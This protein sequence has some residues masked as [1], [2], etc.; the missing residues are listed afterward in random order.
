MT[1]AIGAVDKTITSPFLLRVGGLPTDTVDV[2]QFR[3]TTAWIETV[4]ALEEK[5]ISCRDSLV[6][7]L[8]D[9]IGACAQERVLRSRLLQVKRDVFNMR[10]FAASE[11]VSR[12][13]SVLPAGTYVLLAE[14]VQMWEQWRFLLASG[15]EILSQ[16]MDQKRVLLKKVI[17]IE[18]FR[19]GIAL[20]SPALDSVTDAYLASDHRQLNRSLRTVERSLFEYLLRSAYKTSPFSTFTAV[21]AG[22]FAPLPGDKDIIYQADDVQKKSFT[23]LNMAILTK[24][25]ALIVAHPQTRAELPLSLTPGWRV[26]HGQIRYVRRMQSEDERDESDVAPLEVVHENI[27]YLPVGSLLGAIID[28]LG[29]GRRLRFHQLLADLCNLPPFQNAC[30]EVGAYLAHLI[31]LGLLVVPD[32]AVDMH[33]KYPIAYYRKALRAIEIPALEEVACRLARVE[34]VT[35]AYERASA[36]ERRGLRAEVEQLVR[37]CYALLG[38]EHTPLPQTVLYEDTVFR[39]QKLVANETAWQPMLD[40]TAEFQQVLPLFDLNLPKRLVTR[41]YFQARYGVGGCC[42]DFLSFA[43]DF[44]QR[45]FVHY[46]K[47]AG[48]VGTTSGRR[49]VNFFQQ[50]E[51]EQLNSAQQVLTNAV[52]RAYRDLP[53]GQDELVL[54]DDFVAELLPYVPRSGAP[55]ASQSYF[56]QYLRVNDEARLVI[57]HIYTG[58]T[59]MFSRFAHFFDAEEGQDF[60]CELREHLEQLQPR[61]AVFAELKGG[62]DATNLN[63]HPQ[64]TA[65]ELVCPGDLSSRPQDEQILLEDLCIQDDGEQ[66]RLRLY[67]KRLGKEVIPLYL[68]FL[69]PMALPEIQQVLFNFTFVTTCLL[70]LWKNVPS[71]LVEG[72]CIKREGVVFYP[73][74]RYKRLIL[75]RAYW[76]LEAGVFPRRQSGQSDADFF[77]GVARWRKKHKLPASVFVTLDVKPDGAQ[78]VERKRRTYKPLYVDFENYFSLALLEAT[79]RA[80]TDGV[81]I[82]EM[83]P[84]RDDLWLQQDGRSYV[85]EFVWETNTGDFDE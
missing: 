1:G 76:K 39:P 78:G 73:R 11:E 24:L 13:A 47:N 33:Q 72:R 15:Q 57:N 19:R 21:C 35:K 81:I 70:D 6:D 54:E 5:L 52:E 53:A 67:S 4:V 56:S 65:Y 45:F 17:A 71:E 55:F 8:H 30:E 42:D 10:P 43:Y 7:A 25:A 84:D 41:G 77:L 38:Q 85:S 14:W 49:Y 3:E 40:S 20:A 60:V 74:L 83:L 9:A 80:E 12:F 26:E 23:R 27:F 18:D 50:A 63:L 61:G 46:L 22:K 51:I 32:L 28:L 59:L 37:A 62:Y 66:G 58:C 64:V 16:E 44:R 75:Q 82:T 36:V 29:D 48:T 69:L 79:V 68:G 2:L 31:R 34:I